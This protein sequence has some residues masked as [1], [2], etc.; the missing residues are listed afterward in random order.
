MEACQNLIK[1]M[2]K[3]QKNY[4]YFSTQSQFNLLSLIAN[5]S[6]LQSAIDDS[7]QLDEAI[8]QEFSIFQSQV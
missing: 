4:K 1:D 6:Q 8:F 5:L 3:L 2:D 7:N